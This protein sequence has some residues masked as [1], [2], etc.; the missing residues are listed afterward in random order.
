MKI[1]IKD[2]KLAKYVSLYSELKKAKETGHPPFISSKGALCFFARI[3][4]KNKVH[5][6]ASA[7][8][9]IKTKSNS[10]IQLL[11]DDSIDFIH[12]EFKFFTPRKLTDFFKENHCEVKCIKIKKNITLSKKALKALKLENNE[13]ILLT[14]YR[15]GFFIKKIDHLF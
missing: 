10:F 5:I 12:N 1:T 6:P 7:K 13:I 11:S 15:S 4:N 2:K 14:V 8:G 9:F 3:K